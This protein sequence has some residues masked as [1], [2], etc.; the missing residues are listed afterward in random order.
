MPERRRQTRPLA[1]TPETE[2]ELLWEVKETV[3]VLDERMDNHL[4]EHAKTAAKTASSR[5]LWLTN[6]LVAVDIVA[7]FLS[8]WKGGK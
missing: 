4:K 6:A 8:H 1:E 7:Q 5:A 2:L 3:A